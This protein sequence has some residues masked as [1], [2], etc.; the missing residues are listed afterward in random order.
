[1]AAV[2]SLPPDPA[3]AVVTFN[4]GRTVPFRLVAADP[5]S[6]IAI[7]RA[8]GISG[9]TPISFGS[10]AELRVGQPVAALGSPLGLDDTVTTGVIS[11]L[12][13]PVSTIPDG[14]VSAVFDAIQTDAALNP[15]NS[16]GALVNMNGELVGMNSAMA[17]SGRTDDRAIP[18]SARV[19]LVSPSRP[20][21]QNASP[22]S[23]SR[24][25]RHRTDGWGRRSTRTQTLTAPGSPGL[26]MTALPQ[27]AAYPLVRL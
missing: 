11:A 18:N 8:E 12:N 13:R 22:T 24:R 5:K 27:R 17:A 16:G 4:A 9:L 21:P 26:V 3:S 23:S 15:G 1:M 20:I 14:N 6:D 25:E 10:S 2:A 19:D 7:I